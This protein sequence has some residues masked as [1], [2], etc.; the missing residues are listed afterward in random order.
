VGASL[1]RH[2]LQPEAIGAVMEVTKGLKRSIAFQ[3]TKTPSPRLCVSRFLLSQRTSGA[4]S[5][6]VYTP[7]AKVAHLSGCVVFPG[8][9]LGDRNQSHACKCKPLSSQDIQ[10]TTKK[11]FLI[12]RRLQ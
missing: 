12:I 7:A 2:P 11:S 6:P 8:A 4:C 9:A 1:T 5:H 10:L 3:E